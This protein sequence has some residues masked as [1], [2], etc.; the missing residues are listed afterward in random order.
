MGRGGAGVAGGGLGN[1]VDLEGRG[2][3]HEEKGTTTA[4]AFSR[5]AAKA[6]RTAFLDRMNRMGGGETGGWRRR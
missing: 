6:Q 1:S 4:T 5:E 2:A 3:N